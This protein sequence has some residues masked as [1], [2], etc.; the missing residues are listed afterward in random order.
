LLSLSQTNTIGYYIL[1]EAAHGG[2]QRLGP[3]ASTIVAE[4]LIG[5]VRRSQDS[6]LGRAH[7]RP[8]LPSPQPGTFKLVDLLRFAKLLP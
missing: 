4:V 5:L 8:S 3:V 7:W 1:A 2:G 6:I